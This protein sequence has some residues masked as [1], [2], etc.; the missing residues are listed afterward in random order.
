M[1]PW[2]SHTTSEL[3]LLLKQNA[4]RSQDCV[5][6]GIEMNTQVQAQMKLLKTLTSIHPPHPFLSYLTP[7]VPTT[8]LSPSFGIKLKARSWNIFSKEREDLGLAR[9]DE[10]CTP[11]QMPG[12]EAWLEQNA[13]T[14]RKE[15]IWKEK[16]RTRRQGSKGNCMCLGWS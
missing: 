7:P 9:K 13:L 14:W 4:F 1:C 2:G 15:D 3:W 5:N 16:T 10:Q 8:P 12:K 11:D 6:T